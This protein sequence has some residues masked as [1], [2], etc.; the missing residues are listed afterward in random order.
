[1]KTVLLRKIETHDIIEIESNINRGQTNKENIL[2]IK[3][4]QHQHITNQKLLTVKE[5]KNL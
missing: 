3:N 5:I 4:L 2:K 1:M